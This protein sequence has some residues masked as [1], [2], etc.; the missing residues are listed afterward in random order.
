MN[1]RKGLFLLL[2][3]GAAL[4]LAAGLLIW[5]PLR[6]AARTQRVISFIRNPADKAG[7]ILPAGARCGDAPFQLPTAG[8]IGFVWDDA[9]RP[10]H[11]HTGLDIFAG[12]QPGDTPVYAAAD[13][14]LTRLP[15][16]KSTL[17]QRIPSDPLQPDRQIWIYYTHLADPD[18][19]SLID[20]AFPPD[21]QDVFIPAGTLLGRQGNFSGT[22]GSPVG[23][24]L[25]I[26]IVLDDGQGGFRNE[27]R[28]E[29]TL[30][31]SPYFGFPLNANAP[32][33]DIPGAGVCQ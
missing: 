22:P 10:L 11:R 21:T 31:P 25:H 27:S 28:I 15:E 12:T 17:I 1:R 18:G 8:Y 14:Y 29:N 33:E 32:V 7:W 9:F 20:A 3:L 16:W 23:V 24:H 26:S 6:T 13:G 4:A 19:A 30:D 2:G 5:R